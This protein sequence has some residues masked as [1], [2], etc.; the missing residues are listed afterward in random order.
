MEISNNEKPHSNSVF[1]KL[2]LHRNILTRPPLMKRVSATTIFFFFFIFLLL[3]LVWVLASWLD[4]SIFSG[5]SNHKS[6]FAISTKN[7]PQTLEFP[8]SCTKKNIKQT[9]PRTYPTSHNPSR[10]SNLTCPSYFRWIHEDLGRWKETG[11]TRE[12]VEKARRTAHFRLVIVDGKA[13]IETYR[14]SFQTRDVFTQWGILQ[15]LRLYP[16]KLPDLELMFDCNDRPVV[17]SRDFQDTNSTPPLLFR[18]CSD[19]SSLDVAFPDW[20]FWGWA[21]INIKPWKNV[22][23]AIKEGNKRTKWEDRKPYAYWRG[24]PYV[25]PTRKDLLKCN[26]SNKDDWNTRLYIQ[27][28]AEEHK[29]GY[30]QSK[31]E[32]QC[33]HRYKIYTEGQAW[34]VSEKY[35]MACDSM[36]L[37]IRSRYHD[38][39]VRGM[40]PLEHYWPI[41]DNSKCTSLKF[42]VDWGNN[43]TQ[44]AKAIGEAGSNFIRE[45]LKMDYVYDYMFHLLNEYAKLLKF[46]PTI[47][48][49]TVELCAETMACPAT[50]LW[51]DFMVESMVKSPSQTTPCNLPPHDPNVVGDLFGRKV[52]STKRVEAW[53][54]EYWRNQGLNKRN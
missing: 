47:P 50:G 15:L 33:T 27:N 37:F 3:V 13:Y 29:Q 31:L 53:E 18:Y 30:K 35:I 22:L 14:R 12:M 41:R 6:I 8:L 44:Q 43:H 51:K 1:T 2:G 4:A 42:A 28:W 48:P 5:I 20:S 52:N 32:D 23:E 24:N 7:S 19:G 10:P 38:F 40:T 17:R 25:A 34:S 26:V 11:I 16:G 21:E 49:G 45:H 9:C 46:K 36:T 54:N 39:F